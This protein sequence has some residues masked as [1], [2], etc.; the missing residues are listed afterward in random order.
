MA[1]SVAPSRLNKLLSNLGD[2]VPKPTPA[3]FVNKDGRCLKEVL[4]G[5]VDKRP[6]ISERWESVDLPFL[7]GS[8]SP[9]VEAAYTVCVQMPGGV[10]GVLKITPEGDC[11]LFVRLMRKQANAWADNRKMARSG[12]RVFRRTLD[13]KQAF[14]I[15][16]GALP[17]CLKQGQVHHPH[18]LSVACVMTHEGWLVP[19]ADG[20]PTPKRSGAFT[21]VA[22]PPLPEYFEQC[23]C[24]MGCAATFVRQDDD[25]P[26]SSHKVD[27]AVWGETHEALLAGD[28]NYLFEEA[29]ANMATHANPDIFKRFIPELNKNAA[30]ACGAL[31]AVRSYLAATLKASR[32]GGAPEATAG[33]KRPA[34]MPPPAPQAKRR[35]VACAASDDEDD[36]LSDALSDASADRAPRPGGAAS[37]S[38]STTASVPASVAF[39]ASASPAKAKAKAP[40]KA[41]AKARPKARPK[42]AK[43]GNEHESDED[44]AAAVDN[45]AQQDAELEDVS[46]TSEEEDSDSDSEDSGD[47]GDSASS[48]ASG[49]TR[50]LAHS[51]G[52]APAPTVGVAA[53]PTVSV[54]AAPAV[55][56]AAAPTAAATIVAAPPSQ[57]LASMLV[58]QA[59]PS[60]ARLQQWRVANGSLVAAP[61]LARIDA[62][63]A[64]LT[65]SASSPGIVAAA[66]SLACALADAH[67]DRVQGSAAALTTEEAQRVHALA[68]HATEF[69]E[70]IRERLNTAVATSKALAASLA[71]MEASGRAMLEAVAKAPGAGSAPEA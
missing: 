23:L 57:D 5:L 56:V 39:A 41:P 27:K 65:A 7:H 50:P 69:T 28:A 3:Q 2:L 19:P 4:D 68:S 17:F 45:V 29:A 58:D 26:L 51:R 54:A 1:P 64:L 66:L 67:G 46:S 47:S 55:S 63:L 14:N 18:V 20:T 37:S 61:L 53:A 40:A 44:E 16:D 6:E 34:A 9:L 70:T 38:T 22:L 60:C 43:R 11:T 59:R 8:A 62:D 30:K 21:L 49:T 48:S 24:L 15:L 52:N 42:A 33:V 32:K 25:A 10:V 35:S 13:A 12:K 31:E 71:T 36:A